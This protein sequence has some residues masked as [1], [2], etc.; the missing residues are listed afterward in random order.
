MAAN[1]NMEHRLVVVD[2][3]GISAVAVCLCGRS[4]VGVGD[5]RSRL[6]RYEH[7]LHVFDAGGALVG[8]S[9]R[10]RVEPVWGE[11]PNFPTPTRGKPFGPNDGAARREQVRTL[12]AEGKTIPEIAMELQLTVGHTRRVLSAVSQ[13]N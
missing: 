13:E 6:V 11:T 3:S 9:G 10:L 8:N 7:A 4:W 2:D 12:A 1:I 5:E